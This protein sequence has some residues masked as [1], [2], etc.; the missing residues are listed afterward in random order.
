MFIYIKKYFCFIQMN[1]QTE[2]NTTEIENKYFDNTN[3]NYINYKNNGKKI[4]KKNTD[5][6]NLPYNERNKTNDKLI[7]PET[8]TPFSDEKNVFTGVYMWMC[9]FIYIHVDIHLHSYLYTC[10]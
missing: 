10:I 5:I 1:L 7:A 4:I 6:V 2:K 8:G 9:V 3:H